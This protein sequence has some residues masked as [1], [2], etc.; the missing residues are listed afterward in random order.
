MWSLRLI[1]AKKQEHSSLI[2]QNTR[3][4]W[5]KSDDDEDSNVD[6][7]DHD[8]DIEPHTASIPSVFILLSVDDDDDDDDDSNVDIDD[9]DEDIEQILYFRFYQFY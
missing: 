1:C 2:D 5:P 4:G 9:H 6:I 8:E 7:N 3:W